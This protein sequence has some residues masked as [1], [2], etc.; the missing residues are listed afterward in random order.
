MVRMDL[1]RGLK[2]ISCQFSKK[3]LRKKSIQ[4]KK[5]GLP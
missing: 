2:T 3:K 1:L 5:V 4:P